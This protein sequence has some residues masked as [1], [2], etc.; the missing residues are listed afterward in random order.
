MK[1]ILIVEDNEVLLRVVKNRFLTSG[2]DVSVADNGD[3]VIPL[4]ED[5]KPDLVLLDLI[6]PG[7]SGFEVLQEMKKN[8][9]L[10]NIPVIVISNLGMEEDVKKALAMGANDYFIK[11]QHQLTE[12]I[13]KA[14][15]YAGK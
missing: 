9:E 1:K 10:K 4:L 13:E 7:K 6:L 14:E 5:G 15:Q 12:I 2:W 3:K 11:T 8:P